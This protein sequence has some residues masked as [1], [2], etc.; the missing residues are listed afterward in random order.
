MLELS[1][2]AG[3]QDTMSHRQFSPTEVDETLVRALVHDQYPRLANATIRFAG[4]GWDNSLFRVGDDFVTRLPRHAAAAELIANEQRWLPSLAARLPL[5][6][7]APVFCGRP[8]CGFPW[9]WT[10]ASW[11]PGESA[12][13]ARAFDAGVVATDLAAFLVALHQP[14]PA[15]APRNPYRGIPLSERTDLVRSSVRG[16]PDPAL[17]ADVG[18]E[19]DR[20]LQVPPWAG[21]PLWIHG[22]LHPRNLLVHTGRLSAVVD[23]GDLTAGDPATDLAVAWMLLPAAARSTLRAALAGTVQSE[24]ATWRRARGWALALGLAFQTNTRGDETIAG[25][26]R[27][28]LRAVL[29][30]RESAG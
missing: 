17:K 11:L 9:P 15:D 20:I 21:P 13:A 14:A 2:E 3:S 10:L 26:G 16:L 19:W 4:A 28:T 30:D 7:P 22:D 1:S 29:D 23:W 18:A 12:A 5:P 6:V 24:D 8:G 27:A 25:I